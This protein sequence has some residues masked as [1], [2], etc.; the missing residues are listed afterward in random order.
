VL[1]GDAVTAGGLVAAGR[2]G[3]G[4]EE[5][6]GETEDGVWCFMTRL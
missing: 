4:D 2:E 5:A 3:D 1:S 6:E